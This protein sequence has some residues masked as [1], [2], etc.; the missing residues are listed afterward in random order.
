MNRLMIDRLLNALIFFNDIKSRP[1]K[2]RVGLEFGE[3]PG[4]LLC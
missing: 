4:S 2:S 1:L 3:N